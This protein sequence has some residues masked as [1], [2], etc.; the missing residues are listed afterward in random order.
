MVTT[1]E[2]FD[3][4][5]IRLATPNLFPWILCDLMGQTLL[6]RYNGS[7]SI[8][9]P[10]YKYWNYDFNERTCSLLSGDLFKKFTHSTLGY[11]PISIWVSVFYSYLVQDISKSNHLNRKLKPVIWKHKIIKIF[12]SNLL[13]S[14]NSNYDKILNLN[15]VSIPEDSFIRISGNRFLK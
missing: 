9:I 7:W 6:F 4:Q 1:T 3:F 15:F 13:F 10:I 11:L 5:Q 8:S 2:S 12:Y 14:Y